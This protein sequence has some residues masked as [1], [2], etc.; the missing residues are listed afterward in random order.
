MKNILL[1][2]S[3]IAAGYAV[4]KRCVRVRYEGGHVE[5][6]AMV[7]PR[8]TDAQMSALAKHLNEAAENIRRFRER[9]LLA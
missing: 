4:G 9:G 2:I 8:Y 7:F 5:I 6:A 3:A 1:L